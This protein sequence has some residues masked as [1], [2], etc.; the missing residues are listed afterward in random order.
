[1]YVLKY[2]YCFEYSWC[3]IYTEQD[4]EMDPLVAMESM[5]ISSR[6]TS[7]LEGK[8]ILCILNRF[9]YVYT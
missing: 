3:I 2:I 9:V 7:W 8:K 1:M 6:L 5:V 4:L